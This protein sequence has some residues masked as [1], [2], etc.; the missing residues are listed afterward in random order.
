VSLTRCARLRFPRQTVE[1]H[2]TFDVARAWWDR[3][4]DD[5]TLQQ[6]RHRARTSAAPGAH[7]PACARQVIARHLF[8]DGR[9]DVA[10]LYCSET[11]AA[12]PDELKARDTARSSAR[13][14]CCR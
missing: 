14:T 3:P 9:F 12:V 13:H 6:A 5:A 4:F 1:K 7:A 11:G 8:R 10:Q 2:F